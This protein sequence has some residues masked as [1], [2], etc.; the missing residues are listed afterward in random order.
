MK[1]LRTQI[2]DYVANQASRPLKKRELAQ[3]MGIPPAEY[4]TF[5]R[6]LRELEREAQLIRIR[7]GRLGVPEK[8]N[9]VAGRL[10]TT[11]EGY[12]FVTRETGGP[13]IYISGSDM[14]TALHGDKVVVRLY[15]HGRRR[16]GAPEGRI[17]RVVDRALKSVVGVYHRDRRFGY[18]EPDDPRI[19]RN[20]YVA[21]EDRGGAKEGQKV[22]VQIV[23]WP[24]RHLNP[25]GRVKEVLGYPD[26]SGVDILSV[27]KEYGLPT[28]FPE[29][30]LREAEEIPVKIP[31]EELARREDLRDRVVVT[32]DPEDAKDFDDAVSLKILENGNAELGVHIADVS[33]YVPE[34]GVLDREAQQR[35]TSVYL[36][37]RVIPMLPEKLS[38]E[39]CSLKP[40][41]DRLTLSVFAEIHPSSEVVSYRFA[42]TVIRSAARLTYEEAHAAIEGN[43]KGPFKESSVEAAPLKDLLRLMY[44]LS[45]QL[46]TRRRK[47]GS[48]D[49]DLPDPKVT[50]DERGVPLDIQPE[51]RL[52][53]HRLI[54]ECMLLANR[55][56]AEHLTEQGVP[57]LYRVHDRP[58]PEK[59]KEFGEVV[60]ALGYGFRIKEAVHPLYIQRLL[61]EV[62][63]S[64]HE[65]LI[66][67][68]LLRAMK[69][70]LYSP[71][72]IGHFGLA[73]PCYAHFTSPIRRY[74]DLLVHR[75]LREALWTGM[76]EARREAIE[77][78]LPGIGDLTSEREWMANE[79]E[80]NSVKIK[81]VA[82]MED[83]LGETFR[84][85]ISSVRP[86][87]FF[88]ELE[89]ILVEG[90]V[91]VTS[92]TDDYYLFDERRY[93]LTGDHTG[94]V[95][96]MGD[97]V[98]VK[99]A[100]ADR[101]TRQIDFEWIYEHPTNTKRRQ[102]NV[103]R[104]RR[105]TIR[106]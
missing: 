38:S 54:E 26:E 104:G 105:S 35:G 4:G 74:P 93:R 101:L 1:H 66:N 7:G 34:G 10:Q 43:G 21:E 12:G 23:G 52:K 63:G 62:A 48:L 49:F 92:L 28:T 55:L 71:T 80:R 46:N 60:R 58:D 20:I 72:N 106:F 79:A 19:S 47:V 27:I 24:S 57:M 44:R 41:A 56:V 13:D 86:F 91:H 82:F 18:V 8:M 73:F 25:E 85:I 42:E 65:P 37:D 2:L 39:V 90:L 5:R 76:D 100:R 33:F 89:E 94:K 59:L 78:R 67:E 3:A 102:P 96:K 53:S 68:I 98:H 64:V 81:Q 14:G 11:R 16:S 15:S 51:Q 22:L 61:K 88:V 84:G 87:G 95:F 103:R 30:V 69:R 77:E 40:H 9:L 45:M 75:L 29:E 6:V 99:V 32:I 83:K 70:A 31:P 50:L 17:I 97:R 36:V